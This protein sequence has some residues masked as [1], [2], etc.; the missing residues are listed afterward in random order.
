MFSRLII[1][2]LLVLVPFQSFAAVGVIQ[3]TDAGST[4]GHAHHVA[5]RVMMPMDRQVATPTSPH[6]VR[7]LAVMPTAHDMG[8]YAPAKSMVDSSHHH[9]HKSPCCCDNPIMFFPTAP[10][11]MQRERLSATVDPERHHLKSVYLDGPKRPPR[12]TFS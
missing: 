5:R 11:V 8:H 6:T 3:C 1:W 4:I 12:L 2:L 7:S 9:S 10:L